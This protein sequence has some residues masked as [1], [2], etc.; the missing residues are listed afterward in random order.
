[1]RSSWRT[2]ESAFLRGELEGQ[3][4]RFLQSQGWDESK[5]AAMLEKENKPITPY[6]YAHLVTALSGA[7]N[8]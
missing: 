6:R 3:L 1:M 4:R 2:P 8:P 5:I 7:P